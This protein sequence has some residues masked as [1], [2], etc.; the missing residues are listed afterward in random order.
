[1]ACWR[2]RTKPAVSPSEGPD[3]APSDFCVFPI[4]AWLKQQQSKTFPTWLSLP[5]I[6]PSFFSDFS[7]PLSHG[8]MRTSKKE[9]VSNNIG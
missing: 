7:G 9:Q 5:L 1:M 2:I 6:P 8:Q 3:R 4:R